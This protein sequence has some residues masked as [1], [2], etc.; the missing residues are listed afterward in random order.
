MS[1]SIKP[2]SQNRNHS[3]VK[4]YIRFEY[5][6]LAAIEN[7]RSGAGSFSAWVKSACREKL[8][9]K[10]S[11]DLEPN[12]K[13]VADTEINKSDRALVIHMHAKGLFNQQIADVLNEKGIK[14]LNGA[15]LWTRAGVSKLLK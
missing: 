2:Y 15:K 7:H 12:E 5:E 11:V 3:S 8:D 6:L 1:N 10:N 14:P 13:L 4:K 9:L